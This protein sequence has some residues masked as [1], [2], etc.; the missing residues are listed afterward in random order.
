MLSNTGDD[1]FYDQPT[2]V[3]QSP[4]SLNTVPE[5]TRQGDLSQIMVMLQEQQALLHKVLEEQGSIKE[6]QNK[7]EDAMSALTEEVQLSRS[8]VPRDLT[9]SDCLLLSISQCM[10]GTISFCLYIALLK[11]RGQ[12]MRDVDLCCL[13]G[14]IVVFSLAFD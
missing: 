13:V 3:C 6:R 12:A 5:P 9:V 1:L 8:R 7:M 4:R 11:G 10:L 2:Q 14:H